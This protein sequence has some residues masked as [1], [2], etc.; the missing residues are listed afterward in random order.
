L[1]DHRPGP[2]HDSQSRPQIET[3][4]PPQPRRRPAAEPPAVQGDPNEVARKIIALVDELDG[5]PVP[6]QER[7]NEIELELTKLQEEWR[8]LT[9]GG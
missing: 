6:P 9:H 4:M 2:Q 8:R 5:D 3:A 1:I 7:A